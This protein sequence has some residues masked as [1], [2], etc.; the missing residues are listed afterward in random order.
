MGCRVPLGILGLQ[1][2]WSLT[3]E[4]PGTPRPPGAGCMEEQLRMGP[5]PRAVG[6]SSSGKCSCWPGQLGG[7]MPASCTSVHWLRKYQRGLVGDGMDG[8]DPT[9]SSGLMELRGH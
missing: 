4:G 7:C 6:G 8:S 5:Y 3:K 9:S 2:L 1:G